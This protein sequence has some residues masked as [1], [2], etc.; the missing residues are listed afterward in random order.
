MRIT[1]IALAVAL[2]LAACGPTTETATQPAI[3]AKVVPSYY[4]ARTDTGPNG[5]PLK[6][7]AVKSAYLNERT[8][9]TVVPYNGPEAPGTLVVDP[10]A[11]LLY[12]IKADGTAERYGVAV[13]KAGQNFAGN[14]VIARKAAWPSWTPTTNMVNTQP[15]LYGPLKGGM[16]GGLD[17]P[18]GSRALYLYQNG[19]DTYYR[20]H[21]TLDPSS[22]GKATSAGCIRMF[23]QDVIDLFNE[24]P[25]GTK[26]HVR[27]REESVQYEGPVVE[28]PEGYAVPANQT[29]AAVTTN[30]LSPA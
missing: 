23:N 13:G 27:S 1:P 3:P 30:N 16:P 14:G 7:D 6:I 2:G 5:E 18:L 20:I 17:N 8:L 12:Y 9:R 25:D 24:V 22:I 11:R 28:T 10:F 4:Q 26:I 15:E 29:S 21:G 19:R